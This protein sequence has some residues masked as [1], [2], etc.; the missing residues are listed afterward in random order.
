[1]STIFRTCSESKLD[2]T[3]SLT[4]ISN[5]ALGCFDIHADRAFAGSVANLRLRQPRCMIGDNGYGRAAGDD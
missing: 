4:L 1:M 5:F 3:V 2:T